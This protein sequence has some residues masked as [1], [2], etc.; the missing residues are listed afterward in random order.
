MNHGK[1]LKA[2]IVDDELVIR[3]FLARFLGLK[4]IA[5]EAKAAEDGLKA[6]ELAQKEKFDIFFID[7]R[8]SKLNGLETLKELRKISPRAKHVMIT[9]YAVDDLLEE[10]LGEPGVV[11]ALRKP[12]DIDELKRVLGK[13][14]A[15]TD[16]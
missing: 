1:A 4:D 13:I 15:T 10:A 3:D 14:R 2:L 9:G 6:I 16:T 5:I 8:M 11:A 7:M 12:F